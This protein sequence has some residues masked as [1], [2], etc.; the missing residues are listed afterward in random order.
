MQKIFAAWNQT[1]LNGYLIEITAAVLGHTDP[2]TGKPT[3]DLILD[4]AGQKGTGKW[5]SQNALDLGIAIP[6]INAALEGR[7]MSGTRDERI[8]ASKILTGPATKF[9][10]DKK[11]LIE[12]LRQAL[13]LSIVTCYAQGFALMRE[14]S[15][16]YG[17]NLHFSEIARIWKGGCIIRAKLLEPI[18]QAL[19]ENPGLVNLLMAPRFSAIANELAGSLRTIVKHAAELGVPVL[20]L[21]ASLNY[22]D[23]YRR[24]RMPANLLQAQRDFFGAHTYERLDKPAGQKFHTHWTA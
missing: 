5:T 8:S 24:A 18:K 16:E 20:A 4:K 13:R 1:E 23:A 14:A 7:I 3:V 12:T 17:Y 6:T 19:A 10:G 22:I 15:K 21:S 11:A 2:E 9:E